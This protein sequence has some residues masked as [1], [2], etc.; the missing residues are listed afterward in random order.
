MN[1]LADFADLDSDEQF[2]VLAELGFNLP[3]MPP[4]L[5]TDSNR[6]HGCQSAV[7]IAVSVCDGRVRIEAAS[8]S[9]I[10]RG[11]LYVLAD[12]YGGLTP[13]EALRVDTTAILAQIADGLSG[14]RTAGYQAIVATI[15]HRLI[16]WA[17]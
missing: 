13:G 4:E 9:V 3:D 14:N 12:I 17:A 11:L 8:D 2:E 15:K 6:V 7:W 10:V 1:V 16:G 5:R